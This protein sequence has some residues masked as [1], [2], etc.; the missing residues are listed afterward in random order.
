MSKP[1][2]IKDYPTY[3]ALVAS[4][5]FTI[6]AEESF[7]SYQGDLVFVL[8]DRDKRGWLVVGYGSCSGCDQLEAVSPWGDD[9]DSDW[10]DVIS[11]RDELASEVRWFDSHEELVEWLKGETFSNQWYYYEDEMKHF[12]KGFIDGG[13]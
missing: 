9:E 2:W 5:G 12:V 8:E 7:G 1:E 10:T 11:L 3:H 4:F 6:I 13:S